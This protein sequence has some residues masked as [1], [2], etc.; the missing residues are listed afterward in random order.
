MCMCVCVYVRININNNRKL[1]C[2]LC[3]LLL[4]YIY[5]YAFVGD[6][7]KWNL[8]LD[9]M[10][11]IYARFDLFRRCIIFYF[12]VFRPEKPVEF[13]FLTAKAT[14]PL[15]LINLIYQYDYIPTHCIMLA[16]NFT[17]HQSDAH[18]LKLIAFNIQTTLWMMIII[19]IMSVHT[20]IL[21]VDNV[22]ASEA[23]K[24]TELLNEILC[25][26]TQCTTHIYAHSHIYTATYTHSHAQRATE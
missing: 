13:F 16:Y 25:I 24:A 12:C 7:A 21:Y 15:S 26:Q 20:N 2:F 18:T 8:S 6:A 19:I 14:S 11:C 10:L 22:C 17:A 4:I 23:E 5:I 9:C 3:L 1:L